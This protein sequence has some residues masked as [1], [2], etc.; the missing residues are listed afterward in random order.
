MSGFEV[1]ISLL[2]GLVAWILAL[3]TIIKSLFSKPRWIIRIDHNHYGEGI[4]EL[5]LFT[6]ITI[7]ILFTS[8]NYIITIMS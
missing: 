6:I 8:I 5:I 7:F 2:L 4:F 1:W 3:Y